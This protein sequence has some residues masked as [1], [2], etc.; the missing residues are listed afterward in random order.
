MRQLKIYRLTANK[1][2]LV[3]LLRANGYHP[4][5]HRAQFEKHTLSRSRS[6][7][8]AWLQSDGLYTALLSTAGGAAFLR[9]THGDAQHFI[10][11]SMSEL[12]KFDL[13]EAVA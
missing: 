2:K 9:I 11:L 6:Y 3:K 12:D 8:L 1:T 13:K 4:T 7:W 10:Q 5:V